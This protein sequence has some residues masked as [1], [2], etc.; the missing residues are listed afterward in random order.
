MLRLIACGYTELQIAAMLHLAVDTIN[1][2]RRRV[3]RKLGAVSSPNAVALGIKTRQLSVDDVS[4][5]SVLT[6]I[7]VTSNS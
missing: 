3:F 6:Q 7:P 4:S 2:Y 5:F 1:T